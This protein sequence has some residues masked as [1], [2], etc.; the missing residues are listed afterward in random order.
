MSSYYGQ[1]GI[2]DIHFREKP[3]QAGENSE[4][5]GGTYYLVFQLQHNEISP[6]P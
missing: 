2:F 3:C 5:V 6:F 4:Y 1:Y